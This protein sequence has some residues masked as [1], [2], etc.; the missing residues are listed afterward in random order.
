[1]KRQEILNRLPF[2]VPEAAKIRVIVDTDAKNEAD[3][4]FAIVHHLLSPSFDVRGI[5]AAHFEQKNRYAGG[6]MERSFREIEKLLALAEI[7]DVPA[8]RGCVMP[9][10]H[11]QDVPGSEG[12]DFLIRE[13]RRA[14]SRPLFIAVQGAMT[15][16][17]AALNKAPDIADKI[18]VLWNGGGPY[19]AGRPEFNVMQD[20]DAVRVLLSSTAAVWQIP[21]NV[22]ASLEVTLSEIA[23]KIAPCGRLGGYLLEQL[24]QN[25]LEEFNPHFLLRTGENW[26]LG[27][28]TTIA[29]LLE[30]RFR[31]HW[32][33]A[34][35]PILKNDL[36][37]QVNPHGKPIRIYTDLDVRMT[38]EDLYSKMNLVY[39]SPAGRQ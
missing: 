10:K 39:G 18:T 33:E 38:L 15:N 26:T 4:Q 25:N 29:V 23:W 6:S 8:L 21:Q 34:P 17:A 19:P 32:Y 27:D 36:T 31:N 12:V 7:D 11:P 2:P 30:N 28:N 24:A 37:Y 5:I 22:Y 16:V 3:D 20:P 14:D 35:A 13:A 9:L 1:M